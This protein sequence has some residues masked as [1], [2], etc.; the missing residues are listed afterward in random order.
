[1]K[2]HNIFR[3][4]IGGQ[5][6][7]EGILMRGPR[8]TCTVVRR[9][10]GE[11]V[12]KE[13]SY[14]TRTG[15]CAWPFIRGVV[16]LYDSL[17]GGIRALTYSSEIAFDGI[18]EEEDW[19]TRKLGQKRANEIATGIALFFG[20]AIPIALFIL[21]PTLLA[22]LLDGVIG[23][24]FARNLLEGLFRILIFLG[25]LFCVSHMKDIKRT[26]MYHGAEHKTIHC[27]EHSLPLTVENVRQFPKEHP[28]C[29]T[30]FLFVVMIISILVFSFVSWSNPFLRMLL[31]L[32]LLPVVISLSY[33][34]N[35]FVGRHD[36]ALTKLL[37]APGLLMQKFT[38][39][40]PD[41]GMIEVAIAALERVIPE[42]EGEDRW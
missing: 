33:E 9:P 27:Y 3:T 19:L 21:L 38:T 25:F 26:F 36:N 1:M 20:C 23:S 8:K 4:S 17:S 32:L 30:S 16:R 2:D 15:I 7:I 29:G 18:E 37:R 14:S 41:A 11:L 40:E 28:R 5:A 42:N 35:L 13:E 24:G 34:A 22:G 12:Y 6:L 31:R 10:G 39:F